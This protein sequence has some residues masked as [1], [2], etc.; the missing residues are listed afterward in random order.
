[1]LLYLNRA[2]MSLA[3]GAFACAAL[4]QPFPSKPVRILVPFAA[5]GGTDF[6]ARTV[7]QKMSE[8][9]GQPVVIENKPGASSII[10]AQEAMRAPADGYTLLLGDA[11]TYAVNPTLQKK[12]PYD[13]VKHFAPVTLTARFV[14]MLVVNPTA[15]N[16]GTVKELVDAAKKNPGGISYGT[17]GPGTPHHLAMALFEQRTGTKLTQVPYKGAAPAV[18]DLIGGQIP[19]MF[20]DLPSAQSHLK[21]GK[22]KVIATATPKP[23][24]T[25][26]GVPTIGDS[27][28]AGF[29]AWAWQGFVVPA[30]TPPDTIAKLRDAYIKAVNDPGVRQKL[31]DAGVEPLQ[32]TPQEMAD[33]M[34]SEIAKWAQVI[35]AGNIT[36]E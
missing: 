21:S 20:L 35:Q 14:L 36:L 5:G 11:T 29:E 8:H 12:L 23:V 30:G 7:G 27:G 32:S 31:V 22:L 24:A 28:V 2:F 25:L 16:V 18:Q 17:P 33:Y 13:P 1:M 15:L 4:A 26:P 34:K 19:L 6:F 3:I 9:L 10:A